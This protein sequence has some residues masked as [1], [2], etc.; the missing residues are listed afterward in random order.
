MKSLSEAINIKMADIDRDTGEKLSHEEVY[1]R[2]INVLGGLDE[3]LKYVPFTLEELTE[4]YKKDPHFN[5]LPMK[6]WDEASGFICRE[7]S[8]TPTKTG[9]WW[10]YL[11]HGIDRISNSQGVCILK[12]AARQ[13]VE[14]GF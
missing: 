14:R 11:R 8:C 4:A 2:A 6:K 9:I 3:V 5:N 13:W 10:L 12:E 7:S 1:T